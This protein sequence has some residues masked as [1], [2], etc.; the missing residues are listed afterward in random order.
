VYELPNMNL[1]DNRSIKLDSVRDFFWS[2]N[3]NLLSYWAPEADNSP[4]RVSLLE[5][6]SRKEVRQK[7]LFNVSNCNLHWQAEGKY[8]GVKAARHSKSKKTHYTNFE[9]FRCNDRLVP[10]EMLSM[11]DR[12][13]AFAWEPNGDRFA[14]VHGESNVVFTVTLYTM[15]GGKGRNELTELWS[16][17]GKKTNRLY[18]SPKG[19]Y[20][21]MAGLG[22][23]LN[24]VLEFWDMNNKQC[25]MEQEH[26]KCTNVEWDPSGRTVCT[27][28]CQ[29]IESAYYKFQMD[30]GYNIYSFQGNLLVKDSREKLY[31]FLW[32]PRPPCFLDAEA[33]REVVRNLRK[34]E[35]RFQEGDRAVMRA[36]AAAKEAEKTAELT[37]FRAMLQA[38]TAHYRSSIRP[39]VVE[40]R[41][42]DSEDDE[43]YVVD[44]IHLET[45][46]SQ[47]EEFAA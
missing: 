19:N 28:V 2:P 16:L 36:E 45:Q 14:I 15:C 43:L 17:P 22:D 6:P 26:F 13:V 41:G 40:M 44:E 46:L 31:Q 47:R 12:V 4:A 11:Q 7:N 24:G 30:N 35:R 23:G 27:S 9:I 32:R 39:Q 38:R 37:D 8:L 25:M 29:P 20:V 21:V 10:V 5:I 3:S 1:L 18:W 34:Y 42:Y 33:Q